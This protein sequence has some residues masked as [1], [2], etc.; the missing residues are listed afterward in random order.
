MTDYFNKDL[1]PILEEEV[2]FQNAAS[3]LFGKDFKQFAKDHIEFVKS[4]YKLSQ[5]QSQ[6]GAPSKGC[7]PK[8][9]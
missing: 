8:C 7:S 6:P 3:F 1:H 5:L 4:L 9:S 2:H